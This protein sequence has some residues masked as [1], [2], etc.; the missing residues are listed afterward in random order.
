MEKRVL[1]F[2]CYDTIDKKWLFGYDYENLGGFSLIGE[3]VL[4]GELN[5]PSLERWN[6]I[7]IMQFTGLKDCLGIE[8]Y[9]GD[10]LE[11]DQYEWGSNTGNKWAVE[12]DKEDAC[13][14]TGGGTNSECSEWKRVIG[15]IYENP[16]LI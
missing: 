10:I 12:W 13:W 11:F 7:A 6:D 14:N 5:Q 2:R 3:V 15:N 8:I 9:E 1:K 16:E 4:F